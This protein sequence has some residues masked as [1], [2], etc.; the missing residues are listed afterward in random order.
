MSKAY[1][2]REDANGGVKRSTDEEGLIGVLAEA[3]DHA[4]VIIEGV[5]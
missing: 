2:K 3:V 1:V 4:F 5:D